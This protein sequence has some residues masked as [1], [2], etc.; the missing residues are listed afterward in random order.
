MSIKRI[1][2]TLIAILAL[3]VWVMPA[4]P[5]FADT[6]ADV[7]VTA[8]PAYI[9]VSD[10]LASYDFG[11]VA[12]SSTQQTETTHIGITNTS[13]VQTDITILTTGNFTGGVGW[14]VSNTAT[15]GADTAGLK[16]NRGGTWGAGDVIIE[17]AGGT[18]NYIYENCAALTDFDYGIQLLAPSS[19]SDGVQKSVTVRISAVAG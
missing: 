8:T 11:V 2:T 7:T 1:L 5:A 12:A 18:P 19:F 10:N 3:L 6:T 17:E 4:L 13:T 9:A 14:T 16:S 15:P